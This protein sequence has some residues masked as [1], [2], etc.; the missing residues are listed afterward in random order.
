MRKTLQ[1][2]VLTRF[3]D[4]LSKVQAFSD[5]VNHF[6]KEHPDGF[7]VHLPKVGRMQSLLLRI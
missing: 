2:Q 5:F 6:F 4:K 7:Y 1:Y 3:K